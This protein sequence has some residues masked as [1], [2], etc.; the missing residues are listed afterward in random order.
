MHKGPWSLGVHGVHKGNCKSVFFFLSGGRLGRTC[1][2]WLHLGFEN[3]RPRVFGPKEARGS[4]AV[5]FRPNSPFGVRGQ[6][7]RPRTDLFEGKSAL[8]RKE[9]D[10]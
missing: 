5:D 3:I 4:S 6:C 10:G 7:V 2:V 9:K 8:W 1:S